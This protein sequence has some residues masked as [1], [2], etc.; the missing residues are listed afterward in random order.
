MKSNGSQLYAE[1]INQNEGGHKSNVAEK[2][3]VSG[4]KKGEKSI[5]QPFQVNAA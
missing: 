5:K 3:L 2:S 1:N 4:I